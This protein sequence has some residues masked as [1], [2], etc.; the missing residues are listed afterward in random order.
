M[1]YRLDKENGKKISYKNIEK[2][3]KNCK[4]CQKK[5]IKRTGQKGYLT[6][7]TTPKNIGDNIRIDFFGLTKLGGREYNTVVAADHLT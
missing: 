3:L 2:F 1:R 4:I 6:N 7:F 5:K